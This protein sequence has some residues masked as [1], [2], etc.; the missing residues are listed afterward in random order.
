LQGTGG[1]GARTNGHEGDY[2]DG[3][4][5]LYDFGTLFYGTAADKKEDK[6]EVADVK[7]PIGKL[8]RAAR[9]QRLALALRFLA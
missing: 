8:R 1:R 7:A 4:R 5:S 6:R 2:H 3:L 9:A